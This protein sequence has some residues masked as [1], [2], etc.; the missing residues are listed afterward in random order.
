MRRDAYLA[1]KREAGEEGDW[2][3]EDIYEKLDAEVV[4]LRQIFARTRQETG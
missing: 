2:R 1:A 3:A 4:V